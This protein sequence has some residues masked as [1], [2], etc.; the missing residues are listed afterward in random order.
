MSK[1][2]GVLPCGEK[3]KKHLELPETIKEVWFTYFAVALKLFN[4]LYC[5]KNPSRL[6][7]TTLE[8]SYYFLT[9]GTKVN[10]AESYGKK[11]LL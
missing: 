10:T 9:L 5:R 3:E 6:S 11:L 8:R 4:K 7:E 2:Q 1:V